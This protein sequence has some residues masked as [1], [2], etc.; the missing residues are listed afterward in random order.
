MSESVRVSSNLCIGRKNKYKRLL[1]RMSLIF[2]HCVVCFHVFGPT[3][4]WEMGMR[5]FWVC[6][7]A[8]SSSS[9]DR[10]DL[11]T[12]DTK[13]NVLIRFCANRGEMLLA[14]MCILWESNAFFQEKSQWHNSQLLNFCNS[15]GGGV[16]IWPEPQRQKSNRQLRLQQC[17]YDLR[18]VGLEPARNGSSDPPVL[19]P[20][21]HIA[22]SL[23]PWNNE[24]PFLKTD[25]RLMSTSWVKFIL[26]GL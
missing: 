18:V 13:E 6:V 14:T 23:L 21:Y 7:R 26:T 8:C 9:Y 17:R 16:W 11:L 12:T 15:S 5:D 24:L 4:V 25:R 19:L 2:D 20:P 1:S 3:A 10:R 22:D